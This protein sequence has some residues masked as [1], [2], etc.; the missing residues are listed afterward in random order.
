MIVFL[1]NDH[2]DA[3]F[4]HFGVLPATGPQGTTFVID[5]SFKTL[6][7]T[8]TS[9][10]RVDIMDPQNQTSSNDYLIESMKPGTYTERLGVKTLTAMNCDPSQGRV[11]CLSV[12]DD[13]NNNMCSRSTRL[14]R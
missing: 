7:G 2:G 1:V 3:K 8:G 12:C 5:C 14:L 9:M 4:T 13:H 11:T 6:N 10:L